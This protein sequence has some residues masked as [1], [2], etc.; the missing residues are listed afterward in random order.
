MRKSWGRKELD[1]INDCKKQRMGRG[2]RGALSS[3]AGPDG[4]G[5]GH[6]AEPGVRSKSNTEVLGG[7][8]EGDDSLFGKHLPGCHVETAGSRQQRLCRY[9][10]RR[11][12]GGG[13][14]GARSPGSGGQVKGSER[15]RWLEP[16]SRRQP[17]EDG[18]GP[19]QEAEGCPLSWDL[20]SAGK[21]R[22]RPRQCTCRRFRA[23]RLGLGE[24]QIMS[25]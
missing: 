20:H 24:A 6:G 25:K 12:V 18:W 17:G 3:G 7:F 11:K 15:H 16:L 2:T 22:K 10:T 23:Q 8:M 21:G 13:W 1:T 9:S 19:G 4:A 14:E 5:T